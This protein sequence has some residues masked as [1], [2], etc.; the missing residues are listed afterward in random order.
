VEA[1]RVY[2]VEMGFRTDPNIL[3]T[4]PA[5]LW[6]ATHQ[7]PGYQKTPKESITLSG[8]ENLV[9]LSLVVHY[10][11]LDPTLF[12]FHINRV[13]EI[14]RGLTE[15][16][17]R[18]IMASEE[19]IQTMTDDRTYLIKKLEQKISDEVQRLAI[20]VEVQKVLIH[21]FHPPLEAVPSFRDVFS[22]REDQ[23]KALNEAESYRNVMLPRAR[24]EAE[25]SLAK[26]KAYEIEKE[27][28]AEGDGERFRLKAEAYKEGPKVTEFR[29]YMETIENK[30]KRK[31]K[32][33]ANPNT[34][35]GGYRLW[36]FA[37][38]PPAE[39][40]GISKGPGE[41]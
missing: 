41:E 29:L 20:G 35:L 24:A 37:P 36:M 12:F 18:E 38:L 9:D 40:S 33:I 31:K 10:R 22:A 7:V 23:G 39:L 27:M 17:M 5:L 11:P 26:A 13:E 4:I 1:F 3:K 30:L 8:D 2:R 21:D 32:Y 34:N 25:I 19:S 28:T 6:E 14:M 16:Y 15:S